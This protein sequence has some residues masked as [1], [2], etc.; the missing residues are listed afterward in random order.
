MCVGWETHSG[1]TTRTPADRVEHLEGYAQMSNQAFASKV[2]QLQ[3]AGTALRDDAPIRAK[4]TEIRGDGLLVVRCFDG[5]EFVCEWLEASTGDR[6][7][8]LG[9]RVLALPPV[10][11]QTGV[12]LGRIG[13]YRAPQ[14]AEPAKQVTIEA[15]ESLSLICGASSVDLRTDGKVMIRGEDVLIRARRTQRIKAGTVNIN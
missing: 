2:V 15:T 4:L 7:L 10:G 11:G 13:R 14:V 6:P 8:A 5:H 12:V 3:R 9:D 1:T